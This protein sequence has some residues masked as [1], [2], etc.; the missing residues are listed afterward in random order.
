LLALCL[1]FDIK[2]MEYSPEAKD[3]AVAA[4][5]ALEARRNINVGEALQFVAS[6]YFLRRHSVISSGVERDPKHSDGTKRQTLTI[7]IPGTSKGTHAQLLAAMENTRTLADLRQFLDTNYA[8]MPMEFSSFQ[9][10]EDEIWPAAAEHIR[11]TPRGDKRIRVLAENGT[12]LRKSFLLAEALEKVGTLTRFVLRPGPRCY[13]CG[14][15]PLDVD[16]CDV[17]DKEVCL[18]CVDRRCAW[19]SIDHSRTELDSASSFQGGNVVVM[20]CQQCARRETEYTVS[21]TPPAFAELSSRPFAKLSERAKMLLVE[22]GEHLEEI[23]DKAQT[24]ATASAHCNSW[25][26]R[27]LQRYNALL[28]NMI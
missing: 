16:E 25:G 18:Q 4:A 14:N 20:L 17:C 3:L 28:Q 11:S 6:I 7:R 1:L 26:L 5:D 8:A 2:T 22:F 13:Y 15:G 23:V 9:T 10:V 27:E 19:F 12:S 21:P 24:S